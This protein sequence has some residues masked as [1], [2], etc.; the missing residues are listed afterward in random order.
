MEIEIIKGKVTK[1]FKTVEENP[2][3]AAA[4]GA[5]ITLL[6]IL[7]FSILKRKRRRF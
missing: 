7:T 6:G 4:A 2:A 1:A 5:G 3:I